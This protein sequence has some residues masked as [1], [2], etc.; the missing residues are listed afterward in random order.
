ML[1]LLLTECENFERKHC[2]PCLY[3][4]IACIYI[5]QF[6]SDDSSTTDENKNVHILYIDYIDR[7]RSELS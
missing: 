5:R 2:F 7:N 3:N 4:N 6:E 1:T